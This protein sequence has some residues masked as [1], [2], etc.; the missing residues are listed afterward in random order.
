MKD[1]LLHHFGWSL[2]SVWMCLDLK[3]F[4]RAT[5]YP[6]RR[7]GIEIWFRMHK[8][9]GNHNNK[10]EWSLEWAPGKGEMV[11]G[12]ILRKKWGSKGYCR[13]L[14]YIVGFP[15]LLSAQSLFQDDCREALDISTHLIMKCY[16]ITLSKVGPYLLYHWKLSLQRD[17]NIS[18][19]CRNL[20]SKAI[21]MWT[22]RY[23]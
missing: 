11:T 5:T 20:S 3:I 6:S 2:C 7:L 8:Q 14:C 9:I 17:L 12:T 16:C 15:C 22:S 4:C 21:T 13:K 10:S 23:M 1:F 19:S 18:H